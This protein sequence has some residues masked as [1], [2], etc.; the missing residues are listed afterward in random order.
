M[1]I[2]PLGI[3]GTW[4]VVFA[5][6]GDE[7]GYFMR[8]Y[9]EALFAERGLVTSWVQENQSLSTETGI[10]RGLHFQRGRHAETKL[11]RALAGV[12]LDVI[13]DIRLGSPTYGQHVSVELSAKRQN[14]IYVPR[15]FAHGFCVIEAPAIVAYKVD[16]FYTPAAEGGLLWNDPALAIDWPVRNAV[17]S[18]KDAAWPGIADL[19]PVEV[20]G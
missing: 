2:E 6:R 14:A 11:V 18:Q 13:V 19:I 17:T 3:P 12:V 20:V 7:R 8:T 1:K 5:P 9:D 15:G 10:V 16:N 4:E